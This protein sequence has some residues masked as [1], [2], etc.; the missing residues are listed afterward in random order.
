MNSCAQVKS[1]KFQNKAI[2]C[3]LLKNTKPFSYFKWNIH[4]ISAIKL[5]THHR[6][7]I[8][9]KRNQYWRLPLLTFHKW[10]TKKTWD[11]A[12]FFFQEFR[13]FV[14][15]WMVDTLLNHLSTFGQDLRGPWNVWLRWM[16]WP[17]KRPTSFSSAGT[18]LT[19]ATRVPPCIIPW[20]E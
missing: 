20:V 16:W 17:L 5:S 6:L 8:I 11:M 7:G 19:E 4:W 1:K 12:R 14:V 13:V 10:K 18:T 9:Y 2:V 3:S 15:I